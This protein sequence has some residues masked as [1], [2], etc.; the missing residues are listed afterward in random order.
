[1]SARS[2]IVDGSCNRQ[3]APARSDS[4]EP[5]LVDS[6]VARL[7][8]DYGGDLRLGDRMLEVPA[9]TF[10]A[11]AT[12]STSSRLT[13]STSLSRA[14]DW[15]SY[16]RLL[17]ASALAQSN[18]PGERPPVGPDLRAFWRVYAGVTHWNASTAYRFSPRLTLTVNGDNLLGEQR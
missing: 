2:R 10:G 7:F 12:W 1:M 3:R 5:S 14:N 6:R 16:D 15:V 8:T 18:Q 13:L 11:S 9:R 17:L 4:T